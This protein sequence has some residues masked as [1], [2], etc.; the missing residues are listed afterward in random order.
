V[1]KAG[2]LCSKNI[3]TE[4]LNCLLFGS[5]SQLFIAAI[6]CTCLSLYSLPERKRGD[7][8]PPIE[9]FGLGHIERPILSWFIQKFH[10]IGKRKEKA[11]YRIPREVFELPP[12]QRS[13]WVAKRYIKH[14]MPKPK[15]LS[16][17]RVSE[18]TGHASE[19]D[20]HQDNLCERCLH[21]LK[22]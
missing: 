22:Y 10:K 1:P 16:F 12:E 20:F 18:R 5:P 8:V 2:R 7:Y 17:I 9:A 15:D 13:N 6:A 3:L 4:T 14:Q 19:R 21:G 11:K